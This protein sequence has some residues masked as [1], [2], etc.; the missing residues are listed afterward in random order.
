[1]VATWRS[2]LSLPLY[3]DNAARTFDCP[4]VGQGGDH[5]VDAGVLGRSHDLG[6]RNRRIPESE[7][8]PNRPFKQED[9]LVDH[10]ERGGQHA[11][12]RLAPQMAV[13]PDLTTPRLVEPGH[14]P[15]DRRLAAP[16]APHQSDPGAWL[17]GQVEPFDQRRIEPAVSERDLAQLQE[18]VQPDGPACGRRFPG[19]A[20]GTGVDPVA[21]DVVEPVHVTL[22]RLET[23]AETHQPVDGRDECSHHELEG[24]QAAQG[25]AAVH[26]P[27]TA[28]AEDQRRVDRRE[29]GGHGV[30]DLRVALKLLL[31]VDHLGL[32]TRPAG[33]QVGLDRQ[34]D[35]G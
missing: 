27:Q 25:E 8:L 1:M 21:E 23:T 20:A 6:Q 24:H 9:V 15:G 22:D 11:R 26:H 34:H 18:T 3:A 10:G 12:R 19:M 4:T 30:E 32:E 28:E 7:V 33:E 14:Q 13:E 16:R 5:V 31:A 35:E 17:Q 2:S 29:Q